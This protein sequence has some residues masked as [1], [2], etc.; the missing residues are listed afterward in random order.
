MSAD[1]GHLTIRC[2][3]WGEDR[4]WVVDGDP[5]P[6]GLWIERWR[7]SLTVRYNGP[8]LLPD[9]IGLKGAAT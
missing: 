5:V 9:V 1:I 7:F 8:G 4:T 6:D 3:E 2:L